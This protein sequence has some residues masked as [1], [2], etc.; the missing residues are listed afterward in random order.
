MN[1]LACNLLQ[2]QQARHSVAIAT[3]NWRPTVKFYSR[4]Q[5]QVA[6]YVILNLGTFFAPLSLLLQL[7]SLSLLITFDGK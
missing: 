3:G 1:A 5:K 2:R 4:A 7:Y 6:A